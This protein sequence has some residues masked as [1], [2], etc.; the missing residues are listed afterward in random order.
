MLI[1]LGVI[2]KLILEALGVVLPSMSALLELLGNIGLILIVLEASLDLELSKKKQGLIFRSLLIAL[3]GFVVCAWAIAYLFVWYFDVE[4]TI[5]M[6][7]AIPLAIL[8][9]AIIIPSISSLGNQS[10]E[11][12][13]YE[14]TLSDILGIMAFYFLLGNIESEDTGIVVGAKVLV[15]IILTL[16]LSLV[17]SYG[18]IIFL[19]RITGHIKL[20]LT[21]AILVGLYSTGKLFH[22]SSL[23]IILV[24][25]LLLR[26]TKLFFFGPLQK[27]LQMR[28]LTRLYREL[29]VITIESAF[30]VRTLFFFL[31]GLS[32]TF[33][34]LLKL[35]VLMLGSMILLIIYVSRFVFYKLV[36]VRKIVPQVFIAPRGL[37][38]ILL[39]LS[40]PKEYLFKEF[41]P[42]IFLFVIIATCLIN[43][44]SI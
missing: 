19:Q 1:F 35:E 20:F 39:F 29:R 16:G 22:M 43:V 44:S 18:L 30:V 36:V 23:L 38:T 13:I 28:S 5:A 8:S 41:E 27:F 24:F 4:W 12:L 2:I 40:I 42:G 37:I 31:F 6:L 15:E 14:G 25:G 9:S 33:S 11:F 7:Y 21:I 10:Q 3:G 34:S 32:L 17:L 26:N